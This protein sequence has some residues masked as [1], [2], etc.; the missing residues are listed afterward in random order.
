[1]PS[2][3]VDEC[4]VAPITTGPNDPF[5]EACKLHDDLYV[6]HEQGVPGTRAAA[7]T[8]LIDAMAGTI[9]KV[10]GFWKKTHLLIRASAYAII[11]GALGWI[12]W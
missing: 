11:V 1:M 2:D 8:K 7:D 9:I 4:G 10:N 3:N 12:V 5:I 6:A